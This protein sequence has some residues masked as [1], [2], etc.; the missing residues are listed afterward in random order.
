VGSQQAHRLF[1][2][3]FEEWKAIKFYP[4]SNA[5]Q[6]IILAEGAAGGQMACAKDNFC[7]WN[8][9]GAN[10]LELHKNLKKVLYWNGQ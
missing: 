1:R 10:K 9:Q 4:L 8:R 2:H 5:L 7:C 6:E 3:T